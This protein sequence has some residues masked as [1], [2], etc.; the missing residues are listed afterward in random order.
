MESDFHQLDEDGEIQFKFKMQV[1]IKSSSF[2]DAVSP[3]I[4]HFKMGLK[5]EENLKWPN[6]E[7][8]H[9]NK[10]A[11]EEV[12]IILDCFKQMKNVAVKQ[13]E[14]AYWMFLTKKTYFC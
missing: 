10:F 5:G 2:L 12:L 13:N 6:K 14:F 9:R 8:T 3:S 4:E 11:T 7:I 1:A